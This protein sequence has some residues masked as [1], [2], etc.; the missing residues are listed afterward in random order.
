MGFLLIGFMA[1]QGP[2]SVLA[3]TSADVKKQQEETQEKLN[4][5]AS[6]VDT[7]NEQMQVVSEEITILDSQ[8]VD[9][10]TGISVC[11]D[12]II[13]KEAEID[14]TKEQLDA[15]IEAKNQRYY[16]M[17]Q[18]I[19]FMYEKGD[20]AYVEIM[21][22]STSFA[23]MVNKA[24]YVEQLAEYDQS[25]ISKYEDSIAAITVIEE[26]LEEEQADLIASQNEL[27]EQKTYLEDLIDLKKATMADFDNQ[28][29]AAKAQASN[30]KDQLKAQTEKIRQLEEEEQAEREREQAK[31]N[32]TTGNNK[33]QQ[34]STST[35]APYEKVEI[36]GSGVGAEAAR[37]GCEF[38]GNPY[39]Y[40]GTSLTNGTDCSGFTQS[41]YKHFGVSLPRDSTS[42]RFAGVGVDYSEAQPGDLICYAGHVAIYIGNGKIVHASTERTG[43]KIG[44]AT[45]R[46]I[47]AVRRVA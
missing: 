38:L 18:R 41:V 7:I 6:Q 4:D 9:I 22:Q 47:L 30:Y 20:S 42:Q 13:M 24:A 25:L 35:P 45:Y 33:T 36:S 43:I 32:T 44:N 37:Y 11:E 8:L 16:E 1:V 19:K 46:T 3:E 29:A 21:M 17:T 15:A 23:D 31:N 14:Q 5:V 12:E 2:L 34:G 27:N 28:L 10:L 39:V 26:Q 40:G